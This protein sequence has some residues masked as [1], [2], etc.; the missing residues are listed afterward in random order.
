[1]MTKKHTL[2]I[3]SFFAVMLFV[4]GANM[5]SINSLL[6][7]EPRSFSC[8]DI[9]DIIAT[10]LVF[11]IPIF[12]FSLLT[13]FLRTET[14]RAWLHFTYW[15]VPLSFVI[16]LFSSS[17]PSANI[18]GISDQEIFSILTFGLYVLLSLIIIA[19]K[20]AATRKGW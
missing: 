11:T 15:W 20:Y 17:R 2:I 13:Y 3:S 7:G 16:I 5:S 18:V 12:V 6:C 19:W 8:L 4:V 9:I 14:F 1:M 10:L